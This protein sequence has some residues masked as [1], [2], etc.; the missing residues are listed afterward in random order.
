MNTARRIAALALAAALVGLASGV[1]A[2]GRP[3]QHDPFARPMLGAMPANASAAT[4][5]RRA[6]A[7]R[8]KLNLQAV[9]VAGPNSIANVDG[10]MLRVGDAIQGYRLVEVEHRS[11][12]FEKNG[13]RFTLGIG[14]TK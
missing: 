3:L 2:Q 9:L 14:G 5:S 1:L 7:L 13:D 8:P 10:V 6:P 11:A 12:V 4:A